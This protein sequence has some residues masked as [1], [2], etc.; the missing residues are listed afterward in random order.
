MIRQDL[1][2]FLELAERLNYTETADA[3]YM[4]QSGLS[5]N[6]MRLEKD[7]GVKLFD[8]GPH[9]VELT[10]C[11]EKFKQIAQGFLNQC[12]S[13]RFLETGELRMQSGNLVVGIAEQYPFQLASKA[14]KDFKSLYPNIDIKMQRYSYSEIDQMLRSEQLD[15]AFTAEN[16]IQSENG[17]EYI[18]TGYR[19]RKVV[20]PCG[21]RLTQFDKVSMKEL[22]N[23][24]FVF[25]TRERT[26]I[27]L[28][29]VERLFDA[30]D[31]KPNIV[32]TVENRDELLMYVAGGM[33]ITLTASM[34]QYEN[35][36]ELSCIDIDLDLKKTH[37]KY[38]EAKASLR[39]T[40]VVAWNKKNGNPA[41]EWFIKNIAS[42]LEM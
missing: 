34:D 7:L 20:V 17:L 40:L 35:S 13:L 18:T 6:I 5:K 4:T 26:P 25:L 37:P 1:H 10:L 24:H 38:E 3:L 42:H 19:S 30:Y 2:I 15:V 14:I 16:A 31:M 9:K 8:R 28:S 12:D 21:H 29:Q 11:G 32:Q 27:T 33:G 39:L 41:R 36:P 22:R 23:E